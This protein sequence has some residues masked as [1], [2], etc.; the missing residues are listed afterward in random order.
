ME[1]VFPAYAGVIL[2]LDVGEI[3]IS[4]IPRV[5]GGDPRQNDS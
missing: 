5:C 2:R 1:N 4:G 3:G